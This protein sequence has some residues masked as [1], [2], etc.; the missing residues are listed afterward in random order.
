MYLRGNPVMCGLPAQNKPHITNIL[1][2]NGMI[3]MRYQKRKFSP[4][5][6]AIPESVFVKL[7]ASHFLTLG[8]A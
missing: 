3:D 7:M 6:E 1:H 8:D 5:I 4:E 2:P